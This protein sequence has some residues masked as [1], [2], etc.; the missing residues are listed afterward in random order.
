MLELFLSVEFGFAD[1]GAGLQRRVISL[2]VAWELFGRYVA[3]HR[4]G[5][6]KIL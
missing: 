1:R 5:I 4:Q 2:M 3:Q 6:I